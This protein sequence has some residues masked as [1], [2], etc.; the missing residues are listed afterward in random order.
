MILDDLAIPDSSHTKPSLKNRLLCALIFGFAAG[1]YTFSF[2]VLSGNLSWL[3]LQALLSSDTRLDPLSRSFLTATIVCSSSIAFFMATYF[4]KD[5]RNGHGYFFR[6]LLTSLA[7]TAT[8]IVVAFLIIFLILRWS[9]V[10]M[11]LVMELP[12]LSL[13][14]LPALP[15]DALA[16]WAYWRLTKRFGR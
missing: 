8:T 1:I 7:L 15:I 6:G 12:S 14:L 4:C 16:G 11:F 13:P 10:F 9:I 2:F 5:I 3:D